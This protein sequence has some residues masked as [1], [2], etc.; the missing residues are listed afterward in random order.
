MNRLLG[1]SSPRGFIAMSI[2]GN[3]CHM[4]EGRNERCNKSSLLDD[5]Q[6]G[7]GKIVLVD[8]TASERISPLI[9]MNREGKIAACKDKKISRERTRERLMK[10]EVLKLSFV[11]RV[12]T[13]L[14]DAETENFE[15]IIRWEPNGESFKVHKKKAFEESIQ[16]LYLNQTKLRSFQRKVR[17][18]LRAGCGFR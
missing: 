3:K 12:Y 4:D 1:P 11:E 10:K 17:N 7:R 18:R 14:G 8:G 2:N 5:E 13:M 15:D 16:P 6:Y 9:N